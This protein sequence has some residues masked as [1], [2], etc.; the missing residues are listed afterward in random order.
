MDKDEDKWREIKIKLGELELILYTKE[1][2]NE[3]IK[4][5]D[6]ETLEELKHSDLVKGIYE[7]GLKVWECS[8]DLVKHLSKI[9]IK[10]PTINVHIY[11]YIYVDLR[12]GMRTWAPRDLLLVA[13][14]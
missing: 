13:R 3:V 1:I 8:I 10:F 11:I 4:I 2:G 7:G 5:E 12:S 9:D 6:K 14:I